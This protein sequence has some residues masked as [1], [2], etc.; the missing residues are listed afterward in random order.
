MQSSPGGGSPELGGG[1]ISIRRMRSE[2]VAQR[3]GCRLNRGREAVS[4]QDAGFE[5]EME[6]EGSRRGLGRSFFFSFVFIFFCVFEG[7]ENV[8]RGGE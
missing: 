3:R 1:S 5:L 2:G 4:G 7:P 8:T 6:G